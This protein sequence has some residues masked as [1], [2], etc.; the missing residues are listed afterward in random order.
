MIFNTVGVIDE[1]VTLKLVAVWP[2]GVKSP[3]LPI[4]VKFSLHFVN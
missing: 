4:S 3:E 1:K 2:N